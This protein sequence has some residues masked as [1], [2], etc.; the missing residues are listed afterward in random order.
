MATVNRALG[1]LRAAINWGR[2]QDPPLLAVTPFHRFGVNIKVERRNET[3]SAPASGR[4]TA[5]AG[6]LPDDEHGRAQVG[7]DPAMHDRMIGALETC[8][9]QGEMLRI[10]NR[11]V[12][13][14]QHQ[15]V[16]PASNTKDAENRRIPFD[17]KGRLAPILKRRATL[18]LNAFVF[19]SPE[20][21]FQDSF[22]TA[23]ESLLLVANGHDTKRAKPGVARR[24][25]ETRAGRPAVAR[26]AARGCLPSPGGRRRHP[27]DPVDARPLRHQDDAAVPQHHGRRGTEGADRRLGT[28]PAAEGG[29]PVDRQETA[30]SRYELSVI[31]QSG[32]TASRPTRIEM[33]DFLRE[34][35]APCRTRT[36]DLLVRSQTLYP[37]EL[38][39][40][41]PTEATRCWPG[42]GRETLIISHR[43]GGAIH[44]GMTP[45]QRFRRI[46][47][48][49]RPPELL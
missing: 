12:D 3:R 42:R 29:R 19:G 44:S 48:R 8:C 37:T 2:F 13:W 22:K 39:A 23:W 15:I 16:I 1:M 18:G 31:C 30:L 33:N 43:P 47:S 25:R 45:P 34:F 9:R 49:F 36:C 27:H 41:R 21:E 24:P 35:G 11:H 26:S 40:R 7:P 20:G 32:S 6:G 14:S 4:G 46:C 28:S 10:Q 5:P 38:R 17:P